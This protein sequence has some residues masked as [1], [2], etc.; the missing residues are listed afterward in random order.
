MF[1]YNDYREAF[2]AILQGL[3]TRNGLNAASEAH[4]RTL[5]SNVD[6]LAVVAEQ[7]M[8][9]RRPQAGKLTSKAIVADTG[10][11]P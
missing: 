4:F 8:A 2:R 5:I 10:G 3:L 6:E 11:K 9:K 1:D 7:A